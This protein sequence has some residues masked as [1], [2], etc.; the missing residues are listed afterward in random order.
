M[1]FFGIP[2]GIDDDIDELKFGF[3]D[4]VGDIVYAAALAAASV[5]ATTVTNQ[6]G[7]GLPSEDDPRPACLA[8]PHHRLNEEAVVKGR[9]A[10]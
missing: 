6:A 1:A 2:A 8:A 7:Q 5:M 4:V 3:D 9:S 10:A